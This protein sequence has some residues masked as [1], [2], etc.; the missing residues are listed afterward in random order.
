MSTSSETRNGMTA[1]DRSAE[2]PPFVGPA[3]AKI[4][5]YVLAVAA[6]V[7]LH[8]V[9]L[10]FAAATAAVIAS[11]ADW[12]RAPKQP[13]L[14]AVIVALLLAHCS[15]GGRWWA[16]SAWPAHVKTLLAVVWCAGLWLVLTGCL[17]TIALAPL[18]A[19]AWATSIGL[20]V[21]VTAAASAGA[22]KGIGRS[23]GGRELSLHHHVLADLDDAGGGAAENGRHWAVPGG[24]TIAG[25]LDW[26]FW[27]QVQAAGLINALLA[28]GVLASVRLPRTWHSQAATCLAT[29]Y[30]VS[31]TGPIVMWLAFGA[32]RGHQ[33]VELVWLWGG[34]GLF[35]AITFV[36]HLVAVEESAPG[37]RAW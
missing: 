5:H 28:I 37:P 35:L 24:W 16:R 11:V 22:G 20:Q 13:L 7:L 10:G 14:M 4:K 3:G 31:M 25:M 6:I 1:V 8:L 26:Q 9:L 19:A 36:P 17:K 12:P 18:A 34:Q 15:A 27:R 23:A 30:F 29:I 2:V 21:I 32:V 33:L